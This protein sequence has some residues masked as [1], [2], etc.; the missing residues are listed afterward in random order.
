MHTV[1][2]PKNKLTHA[3]IANDT[4]SAAQLSDRVAA[5]ETALQLNSSPRHSSDK[6]AFSYDTAATA[7]STPRTPAAAA[8]AAGST[9]VHS[10]SGGSG[11]TAVASGSCWC[12][13]ECTEP[14]SA[15]RTAATHR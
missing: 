13:H 11:I 3:S 4:S 10:A 1:G 7:P 9:R 15:C 14:C 2:S 5:I 6:R 12:S 8:A